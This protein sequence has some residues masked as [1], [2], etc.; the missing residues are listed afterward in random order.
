[1]HR[2]LKPRNIFVLDKG[3]VRLLDFGFA[4]FTRMRS[5]TQVGMVAGSPSYIAP[6]IWKGAEHLDQRIDVYSLAAVV[7]RAL[8]GTTPFSGEGMKEVLI[9]V[10][11]APRPSLFALRPDLSPRIDDWVQQAL[12]IEP[13]HRFESVRGMWTALASL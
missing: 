7:F 1:L 9:K 10:T 4:K 2:D 5:V 13:E 11:T 6:E 8:A 3:G 12:A